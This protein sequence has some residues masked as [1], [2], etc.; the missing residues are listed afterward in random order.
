MTR[1][2]IENVILVGLLIGPAVVMLFGRGALLL[3][4]GWALAIAAVLIG[5]FSLWAAYQNSRPLAEHC[6]GPCTGWFWFEH[7]DPRGAMA[8]VGATSLLVCGAIR[9]GWER[10][11]RGPSE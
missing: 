4:A 3:R 6:D 9:F 5:G 2:S 10:H 11:A 1:T 7:P 8:L